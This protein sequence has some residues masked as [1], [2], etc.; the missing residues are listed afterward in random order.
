MRKVVLEGMHGTRTTSGF[1]GRGGVGGALEPT[2]YLTELGQE[3]E[4]AKWP[5]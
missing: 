3:A 4:C 2:M 1:R 5:L